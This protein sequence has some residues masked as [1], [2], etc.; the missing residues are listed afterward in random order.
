[1]IKLS[2]PKGILIAALIAVGLFGTYMP[3][4]PAL[5]PILS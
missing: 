3:V 5:S 4:R 2:K 1:M